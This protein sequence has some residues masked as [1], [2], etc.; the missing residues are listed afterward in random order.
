MFTIFEEKIN[1]ATRQYAKWQN[2]RMIIVQ[3]LSCLVLKL[4]PGVSVE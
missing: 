4:H 3:N 1:S 2:H